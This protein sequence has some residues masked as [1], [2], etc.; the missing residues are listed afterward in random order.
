MLVVVNVIMVMVIW[1]HA[2]NMVLAI[3]LEAAT[4]DALP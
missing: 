3:G 2:I 1:R 4:R